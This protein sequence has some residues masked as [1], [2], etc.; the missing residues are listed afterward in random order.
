MLVFKILRAPEWAELD[1]S[2]SFRGS[3]ADLSDGF[4]HLS[5]SAQARGTAA[6]HFKGEDELVVAALDTDALGPDLKWEPA[7]G[8]EDFPHLYRELRRRDVL[9]SLPLPLGPKGHVF[10]PEMA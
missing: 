9:W 1:T 4:V 10:P 2:G 6:K 8:G 7:R 5:T 3:P